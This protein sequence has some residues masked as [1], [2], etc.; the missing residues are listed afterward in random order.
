MHYNFFIFARRIKK[1]LQF[2]GSHGKSLACISNKGRISCT[3]S[4]SC[5][6]QFCTNKWSISIDDDPEEDNEKIDV[7]EDDEM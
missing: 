3:E 2:S 7:L 5:L 4:C 1:L 6:D